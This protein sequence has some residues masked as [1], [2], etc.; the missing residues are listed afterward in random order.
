[1]SAD[2]EVTV[3]YRASCEDSLTVYSA[4][5]KTE[6]RVR[7]I[8]RLKVR[9][10]LYGVD[11]NDWVIVRVRRRRRERETWKRVAFLGLLIALVVAG[12]VGAISSTVALWP[13]SG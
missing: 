5:D 9:S 8:A 13:A 7:A 6:A 2:Y 4:R 3:A 1:M 10:R 12:A 11:P